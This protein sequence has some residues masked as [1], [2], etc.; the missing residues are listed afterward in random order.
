MLIAI[1]GGCKRSGTPQCAALGVAWIQTDDGNMYFTTTYE[2][3]ESTS[4]RGELY[5]LLCALNEARLHAATDEDIIIITDSEYLHNSVMRGWSLRWEAAQWQGGTGP[6]KNT[7][8][9]K[10]VN[11][12]LRIL[13]EP[14]E[15]VFLEWTKGHLI[16]YTTSKIK[17]A[18]N[19]DSTGVELYSRITAM[20]NRV[21]DRD[22][23]VA[24]FIYNRRMGDH[25][26]PPPDI[27]LEWAIANTQADCLAR[28]LVSIM[29]NIII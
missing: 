6:V 15:R 16:H 10:K 22:R 25:S 27:A 20:A 1:D 5:G 12:L 17:Y 2:Q 19:E 4:Q 11:K 24:D 29:D 9:W 18:M 26:I 14:N 21:A 28:Y 3:S 13:N 8:L 23:I 7:D